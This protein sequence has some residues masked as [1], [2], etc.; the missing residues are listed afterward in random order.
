M[1]QQSQHVDINKVKTL[2]LSATVNG[3]QCVRVLL[4]TTRQCP[5]RINNKWVSSNLKQH[6]NDNSG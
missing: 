1:R 6:E 4:L 3:Q 2:A 5:G